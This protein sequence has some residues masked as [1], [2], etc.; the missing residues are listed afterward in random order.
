MCGIDPVIG[1]ELGLVSDITFT[2]S[3]TDGELSA[4]FI[5]LTCHQVGEVIRDLKFNTSVLVTDHCL[6]RAVGG[7]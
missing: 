6:L 2:V 4:S 1:I 5:P 7:L 3:A